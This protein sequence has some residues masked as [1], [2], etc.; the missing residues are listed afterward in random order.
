MDASFFNI[1]ELKQLPTLI[2]KLV[3]LCG[4]T[5]PYEERHRLARSVSALDSG[6]AHCRDSFGR[7]S[8]FHYMMSVKLLCEEIGSDRSMIISMILAPLC[9]AGLFKPE[10]AAAE[11]G[12]DVAALLTGLL[13]VETSMT[14][15]WSVSA[16]TSAI[17]L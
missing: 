14:E 3:T 17:F 5:V 6:M 4:A 10:D 13:K 1:K 15:V 16:R 9:R 12:D 2:R 11:W 8:L 7:N